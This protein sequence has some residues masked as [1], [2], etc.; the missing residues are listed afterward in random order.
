[1]SAAHCWARGIVE[2]NTG[3][4]LVVQCTLNRLCLAVGVHRAPL[5]GVRPRRRP[6]WPVQQRSPG[7]LH[8]CPGFIPM[9]IYT[10]DDHL[11]AVKTPLGKDE[12][13][14]KSLRGEEEF[15]RLFRYGLEFWAD[16]PSIDPQ[17]IVGK[18]I[19]VSIRNPDKSERFFNGIVSRFTY[20]GTGDRLSSYRAEMVP[21]LWLLTRTTD[22][23]IFQNQK[24]QDIIRDVF[25]S[26]HFKS[27]DVSKVTGDHEPREY[28]V[29]YRETDFN[30]VSRL[31]EEEGIFYFFKHEDGKHTLMLADSTSAYEDCKENDL[32]YRR[33][34]AGNFDLLTGWEHH[35]AFTSGKWA[36]T[37]YSFETPKSNLKADASTTVKLDG[38][39]DY[40]IFDYPGEYAEKKV[41]D[42]LVRL[43][44]EEEEVG[45]EVVQ[46]E[47]VCRSFTPGGKFKIRDH[48]NPAEK[49]KTY[50]ITSVSH[51]VAIEGYLTGSTTVSL[52]YTNAFQCVPDSVVLRPARLTPKPTVHGAQT[53]VVVGPSGE[54]IW[55]DK[56]GRVK[57]QFFWD[58]Y[59][60]KDDK[61]SCWIRCLQSSAGRGWGT[62][63]IPRIGQEVVVTYLEG[64]PDR[65]LIVG[66]VYN[67]DQMPA[68]TLPDEKTKS[69]VKTNTSAGGDGF[70]E[71][72]F[73]DLKDKE[74]IFLHAERDLDVRVKN[75]VRR[76]VYGNQHEIIG[77]EKDGDK[78][79]DHRVKVYQ[80]QH[81][82]IL[83]DRVEH[84]EGNARLM[85]GNG[86]ASDG[87]KLDVVVEKQESR[88]IGPDGLHV[89]VE[90][91]CN[92][93]VDGAV[94]LT[95][96]KDLQEKVTGNYA[97][98]TST[99][100][101]HIQGAMN[102]VIEAGLQLTL[103]V[104]G[105]FVSI[106]PMGVDVQGIL[107]NINSG[108]SAG[109]GA[110]ASPTAPQAPQE[111]APTE[112]D[113][114]DD[115]NSG[116][117]SCD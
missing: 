95:V 76:R 94:S 97:L 34:V 27:F 8:R 82:D 49:G 89:T 84:V 61:S 39:K 81:V 35:V 98:G 5:P 102:V 109:S 10:Q 67:A 58:R 17:A 25:D 40:E 70:N 44:M 52:D 59:G 93:K 55:P 7:I 68:Y 112:P 78:G 41:G 20:T 19:T 99:G 53:A 56:Y 117:K 46:G 26:A 113:Q 100:D 43:R 105:N 15:S 63:S 47:S 101:V 18:N 32:T 74:Q 104:G 92:Q 45:H 64:D 65:P 85:I 86:D 16:T 3:Q 21:E 77:C 12:L 22:C 79:G 103:K 72:R 51:M 88:Q 13:Y 9:P 91:D 106:T 28:C 111:A 107:V 38:V 42:G 37:D 71:I 54:E 6:R 2:G 1:M 108:G 48:L 110:G 4:A 31:M 69:Y 73:E 75:D 57:V 60:K 80:D 115:S 11:I 114:A 23:K 90:G 30:F 33:N 50:V 29:Q 14:L 83:R 96:G 87:G 66:L 24:V 36:H 62:M 116:Q